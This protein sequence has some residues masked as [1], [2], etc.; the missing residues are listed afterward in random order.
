MKLNV[1]ALGTFYEMAREGAGLAAARLNS[2][3]ELES[4]VRV[5]RLHFTHR[6]KVRDE[7]DDGGEKVGIRVTLNGGLAGTS[8]LLFDRESA[9]PVVKEL[10]DDVDEKP[11]NELATS[12]VI[13]LCHIMNSGF[14]DGWADVLQAEIDVAAPEYVIG[15][16]ASEFIDEDEFENMHEELALLFQSQIETSGTEFGFEHYLIP[17]HESIA[18]LFETQAADDGIEYEKLTGFDQMAQH[19]AARVADNLTRMTGI[20]MGV[21]IRRINFIS[22][23][24]I[25]ETVPNEPL[26]S[27]AFSFSG[28][29]GGYLLFLFDPESANK[30]V[31]A[32]V[33]DSPGG[34]FG[35]FEQDA[36]KE[37]SNVMTSGLLDGWANM[38]DATIDH[39]TPAYTHDM[40]AAVVDPLIVGLSEFQEFAFVFDTRI[41]ALD[42][43]FDVDIYAI[44][45]ENDLEA[46]L[47]TLDAK[48]IDESLEHDVEDTEFHP[49]EFDEDLIKEIAAGTFEEVDDL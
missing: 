20:E 16:T 43:E 46:A 10:I 19:G 24:A 12:A 2:M 27:V 49:E 14:V 35:A 42:T 4:R 31:D 6:S 15:E 48:R 26:V 47:E 5:T 32:T 38:L 8:L 39:S 37:L 3:S 22:L 23:D 7:L 9:M 40:G 45:D 13:E 1:N 41:H 21:D 30:L 36:I 34:G 25:P 11:T 33:G 18:R 17:E 44:P 28:T 29:L